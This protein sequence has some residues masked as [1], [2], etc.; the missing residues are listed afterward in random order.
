MK[1]LTFAAFALILF[2]P[3]A[4]SGPLHIAASNGDFEQVKELIAAGEDANKRDRNL[5]WPIHQAALQNHVEMAMALIDAGADVN[6]DHKI[7]GSP[8]YS[9][10][11]KGSF[12][13]AV[14][15]LDNGADPN[16]RHRGDGSTPLHIAAEGG[17]ADLVQLLV[18]RGS[19]LAARTEPPS[20]GLGALTAHH[21]AARKGHDHVVTLLRWLERSEG[22]T[23]SIRLAIADADPKAGEVAFGDGSKYFE[24]AGCHDLSSDGT[25]KSRGPHLEGILSRGKAALGDFEYSE[26]M[27]QLVGD[28]S[29]AEIDSFIT[30]PTDYLPG[31]R[32]DIRGFS[33]PQERANIIAY[34]MSV[35]K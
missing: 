32:M 23:R 18:A 5:G 13:L 28:W 9:A 15:L 6:V 35:T 8:L 30:S 20:E 26:Q 33:D 14:L 21:A 27:K 2:A 25:R 16:A 7:F 17:Y 22:P 31:T 19:D 12:E 4:W 34:I 24:C 11:Q 1:Q 10:A 3:A 29:L